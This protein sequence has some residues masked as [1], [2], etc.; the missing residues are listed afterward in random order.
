MAYLVA[1][2]VLLA[3][4]VGF[5]VLTRYEAKRGMRFFAP[6]RDA[7][8]TSVGNVAFI[9]AHVDLAAFAKDEISRALNSIGHTIAHLSLQAVRSVER[10]LTRLVRHLRTRHESDAAPRE[11]AREFVK[12]LSDFKDNLKATHPDIDVLEVE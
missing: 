8:D 1:V 2:L 10:L 7:L 11:S 12:T 4:L 3:L 5:V 9:I 6:E